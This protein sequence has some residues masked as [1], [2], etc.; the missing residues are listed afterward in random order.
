M[1]KEF[2]NLDNEALKKEAA[3]LKQE[4]FNLKLNASSAHLKDTSQF[5]KLRKGVAKILTEIN[6]RGHDL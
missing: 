4:F 5:K 6:S 3:A 2:A 1:N